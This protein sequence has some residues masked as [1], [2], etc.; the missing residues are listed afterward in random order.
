MEVY[1]DASVKHGVAG[2][3]LVSLKDGVKRSYRYLVNTSNNSSQAELEAVAKGVELVKKAMTRE[4]IKTMEPKVKTDCLSIVERFGGS[5]SGVRLEWI[6]R[7]L[8]LAHKESVEA[9]INK[10]G[11]DR[12]VKSNLHRKIKE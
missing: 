9:R 7:R 5:Y 4:D 1:V 10:P 2:I 3:G 11:D 6:P 12:N 8:N